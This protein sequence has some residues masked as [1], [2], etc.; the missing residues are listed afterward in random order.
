VLPES[1]VRGLGTDSPWVAVARDGRLT[2]Q[3]V[4]VGLRTDRYVEILSGVAPGQLVVPPDGSPALG[5]RVR[6]HAAPGS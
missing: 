1:A 3:P 6:V 5:D 2:R 4:E